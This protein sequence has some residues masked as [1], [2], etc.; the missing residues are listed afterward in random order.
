ME[1]TNQKKKM[2][3]YGIIATVVVFFVVLALLI[4]LMAQ[5]AQK[6]KIIFG[7]KTYKTRTIEMSTNDGKVYKQKNITYQNKEL[8]ILLNTEDGKSYYCIETIATMAGYKYN[9]GAYGELDENTNK[10]YIDNGGEFVTFSTESD[11][12]S[13]NI[14]ISNKYTDELEAKEKLKNQVSSN[15]TKI[16]TEDEEL[17]T[18]EEPVIKFADGKLY[19]SYDAITQ[20]FNMSI[21]N[22]ESQ[23]NIYTLEDLISNYTEFLNS[24][25]Y[26]LTK[27]FRNQRSLCQG[28]AVAGKD[29]KYGVIELD[30]NS[31]E[32]VI[33]VKYDTVEYVQSIGE[34]IISSNSMYG[35]IAPGKEK[36]TISLQYDNI[37][38]LDAQKKLYIVQNDKKF[39]VV[40]SEGETVVPTEYDQIGLDDVSIYRNQGIKNKYLIDGKCIPV[41]RNNKYGLFNTE[42]YSIVNTYDDAIGCAEPAKIID[43]TSAMPTL[44]IPLSDNLTC[45]VYGQKNATGDIG[46]GI[47][48]ADD[49]TFLLSAYYTAIYYMNLNGKTTYYFNKL[50]NDEVVTLDELINTSDSLKDFIK[51]KSSKRKSKEQLEKD[52]KKEQEDIENSNSGEQNDITGNAKNALQTALDSISETYYSKKLEGNLVNDYVHK[53]NLKLLMEGYNIIEV[54][55]ENEIKVIFED[56]NHKYEAKVENNLNVSD[57]TII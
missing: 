40:N 18:L 25:G 42:G 46:Y 45:I 21:I 48:S 4:V 57:V 55:I 1:D 16:E 12:I 17:F 23:V 52:T 43:N 6:T 10:C 36:P 51:N 19:A 20:G 29:K 56:N 27:N 5:E 44:T 54:Q 13:K 39:G 3:L 47:R 24:K 30:G 8:P 11:S 26:T 53:D 33:S 7:N 49:G 2:I 35:M 41:V 14:K 28:L 32:E 34:F 31:Y 15:N 37:Q 38:L 50:N 9:K 22:N